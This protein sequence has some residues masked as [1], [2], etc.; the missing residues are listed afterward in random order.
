MP[1]EVL[2]R[3]RM[4]GSHTRGRS[5]GDRYKGA[6]TNGAKRLLAMAGACADVWRFGPDVDESH[7][8]T[9]ASARDAR[10]PA[11][12]RSRSSP[13]SCARTPAR[14][15]TVGSAASRSSPASTSSRLTPSPKA[16]CATSCAE[17]DREQATTLIDALIVARD[18]RAAT[19][20][21]APAA[22]PASRPGSDPDPPAGDTPTETPG[23]PRRERP[24]C[25]RRGLRQLE[26]A[27]PEPHEPARAARRAGDSRRIPARDAHPDRRSHAR[28]LPRG[29]RLDDPAL[30]H[31]A[32]AVEVLASRHRADGPPELV[33]AYRS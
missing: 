2:L 23:R 8:A 33:D 26:P 14:T 28:P 4:R 18:A 19:P 15:S 20:V 24:G 21:A 6:L 13:A 31:V 9:A 5:H 1:A 10:K 30:A 29:E 27:P 32:S 17:L 11:T 16:T 7:H 25:R 12:S 22:S 3:H